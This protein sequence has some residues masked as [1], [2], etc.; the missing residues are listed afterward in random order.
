MGET[1]HLWRQGIYG[2]TRFCCEPKTDLKNKVKNFFSSLLIEQLLPRV[3]LCCS[4][5]KI[6]HCSSKP[7]VQGG[8]R[9][10]CFPF[11]VPSPSPQQPTIDLLSALQIYLSCIFFLS[12]DIPTAYGSSQASDRIGAIAASLCHSHS[13][14][15]A[16]ACGNAG[17]LTN[18][19]GSNLHPHGHY[20]GFLTH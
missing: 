6:C 16:A 10:S 2:K 15:C 11:P 9:S 1:M 18:H 8:R 5:L 4:G 19:Q 3:L 14:T 12:M 13:H 20:V 7:K 17:F